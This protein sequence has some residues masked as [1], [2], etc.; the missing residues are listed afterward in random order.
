[1]IKNTKDILSYGVEKAECILREFSL[2]VEGMEAQGSLT[3]KSMENLLGIMFAQ[4]KD[5]GLI[6]AGEYFSN[7]ELEEIDEYCDCGKKL[8]KVKESSLT[9]IQSIYGYMPIKR[10]T[11][12][13]RR[14]HKGYGIIDKEIG[15]YG[16][17][18]I[19]KGMTERLAYIGQLLPF[20]RGTEVLNKLTGVE[21]SASLIETVSEEI[22]K[23]VFN[24]EIH[25][26]KEAWDKPEESIP[27]ELPRYR[28]EARLYIMTDGLQVNTRVEDENGS[29]WK[30]MKLGLVF[31]D[32]DVIKKGKDSHIITKKEYVSY[33]GGINEFKKVLF[34]AAARAGYGKIAELVV[35]GDG[36][37]WIWNMC[38]ELFPDAV[39]ILD[40]YHLSENTYNYSKLLYTEDEAG[41]KKWVKD[42]LDAITT[43]RIDEAIK[44]IEVKKPEKIPDGVVNLYTYFTNN[45]GRIDYKYYKEKGYYIGSGAI[46]SGNKMVI[47]QRMKQS[48]MRWSI[49]GG[50]YIA[51]LRTKHESNKWNDVTKVIYAA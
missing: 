49:N 31:C 43:G 25:E 3:I 48:G 11:V 14:C 30:E 32:K 2:K 34:A 46:E 44:Y 50:Q 40:F 26:A 4:F 1:M 8:V 16:E 5:I 42:V 20:E 19:T 17:H 47:Q 12:F 9:R 13:C 38:E 18:R 45:R 6:M 24:K 21:V 33:F 35:I 27:Q 51:A 10:D 23:E 28:K 15:I 36:A 41:R 39:Q 7:L 29:T 37:A 22:G